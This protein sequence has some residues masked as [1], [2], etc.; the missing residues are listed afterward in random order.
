MIF[1]CSRSFTHK[2]RN[3]TVAAKVNLKNKS[4]LES[5]LE[6]SGYPGLSKARMVAK[7]KYFIEYNSEPYFYIIGEG[8]VYIF[9]VSDAKHSVIVPH[10]DQVFTHLL[11][12]FRVK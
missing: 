1:T 12:S 2:G 8:I 5:W 7:S 11:D 4:Q 6:S 9:S 10:D 3:Y